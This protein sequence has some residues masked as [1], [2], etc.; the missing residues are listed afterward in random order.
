MSPDDERTTVTEISERLIA[1]HPDVPRATIDTVVGE[2]N[3]D[4]AGSRVR[5]FIPLLV[6][7]Y[8]GARLDDP[9][10]DGPTAVNG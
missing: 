6:E 3:Q 1:R 7:R 10:L 8:A 2:V 4:F 5:V 9:D